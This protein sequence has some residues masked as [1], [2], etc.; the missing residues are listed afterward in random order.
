MINW[1]SI[2]SSFNDKPT[3]LEWLKLVEK[4]LKE[5]VLTSVT[6]EQDAN[7]ENTKLVFNFEDGTQIATDFFP[8]KGAA[9]PKIEYIIG[10][11]GPTV[12]NFTKTKLTFHMSDN[13]TTT[14]DAYARTGKA[15]E[16]FSSAVKEVTDE[17][18]VNIITV[19]YDDKTNNTFEVS[20]AR[21]KQGATGATGAVGPAGPKGADGV[22]I[23]GID[24]VS[25]EVVGDET[26][27]TLRAHYSNNTTDEFVVTAK[28]GKDGSGGKYY[29]HVLRISDKAAGL[30]APVLEIFFI[31]N[32]S[33][34]TSDINLINTV[35]KKAYN[36]RVNIPS[37]VTPFYYECNGATCDVS[38]HIIK[39][40]Y[41]NKYPF[42]VVEAV[43][44][45]IDLS[46]PNFAEEVIEL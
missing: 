4:A 21:G 10:T 38:A 30:S 19:N 45:S 32:N 41:F 8:T 9:A 39:V 11:L 35:I 29:K 22:S 36:Y 18:T 5:S 13:T 7:K 37:G 27:T 6:T 40:Y 34:K 12:G 25:D 26:L 15:V 14:A 2:L 43:Y 3:L 1:K 17:N 16:S 28:N 33:Q 42:N 31:D 46:D 44:V 24:T 20:S 23:T